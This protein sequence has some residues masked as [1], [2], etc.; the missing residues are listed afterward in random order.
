MRPSNQ[1]NGLIEKTHRNIEWSDAATSRSAHRS[2][3]SLARHGLTYA[4]VIEG[5]TAVVKQIRTKLPQ[6]KLLLLAVFPRGVVDAPQRAQIK[7]INAA[8]A[9]LDDGKMIKF[10]DIGK[11]FLADDGSIPKTIMP[12]LLHP[13]EQ[14]YQRW[15]DAMEPTL[16]GL[17]K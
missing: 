15:A 6:S 14:G 17:L 9:Q 13:N 3:R 16:A 10:L 1:K 4:K 11:V 8:I 5:V 12:D 7:E 2:T